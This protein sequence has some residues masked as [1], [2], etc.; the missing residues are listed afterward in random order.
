MVLTGHTLLIILVILT[1]WFAMILAASARTIKQLTNQKGMV[2]RSRLTLAGMFFASLAVG[3]LLLLH[4]TWITPEISQRFG[5]LTIRL[6][7]TILFWSSLTGFLSTIVGIGKLRYLGIATCAIAG[8]WFLFLYVSATI[9]MTGTALPR[10][11]A[12]TFI[13]DGYVG[14]VEIKYGIKSAPPLLIYNLP[15][16]G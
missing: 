9:S 3:S 1:L 5:A 14:W 15:I 10:H 13:P 12:R 11:P 16:S 6:L 2:V 4:L 8:I 7:A